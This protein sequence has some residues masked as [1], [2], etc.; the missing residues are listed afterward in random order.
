[1][2]T[3]GACNVARYP[4]LARHCGEIFSILERLYMLNSFY[5]FSLDFFMSIFNF[6]LNNNKPEAITAE[7][8]VNSRVKQLTRKL[9]LESYRRVAPTLLKQIKF[10]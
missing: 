5:Q 8:E 9:Y 4:P 1:M 7:D 2:Q 10:C 6:L 3:I